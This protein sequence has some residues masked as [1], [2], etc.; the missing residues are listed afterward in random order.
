MDKSTE[1]ENKGN[2]VLNDKR[3]ILYIMIP[4]LLMVLA[5]C[6]T[7]IVNMNHPFMIGITMD[8]NTLEAV[9]I[10]NYSGGLR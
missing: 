5:V 2:N 10:M 6:V 4:L 7:M 8:N 3:W 9:R 1:V